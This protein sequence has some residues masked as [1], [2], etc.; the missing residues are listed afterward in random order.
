MSSAASSSAAM[1]P[2]SSSSPGGSTG[3]S[4]VTS[5]PCCQFT[6]TRR[7][8]YFGQS[9]GHRHGAWGARSRSHF[10]TV[11]PF[12][13]VRDSKYLQSCRIGMASVW[14]RPHPLPHARID[15]P[16][17]FRAIGSRGVRGSGRIAGMAAPIRIIRDVDGVAHV[18]AP[19]VLAAFEGQGFAAA[20]DRIWQMELDRRRALGTLAEVVGP[21]A[22]AV[23]SFH[24]RMGL[25]AHARASLEALDD[26]TRAVLDAYAAGVNRWLDSGADLPAEL[27]ALGVVPAPW[28][29]WH[30]IALYEVRH[31]AMGTY[32]TKLWRSGLVH[33]LGAD[34]VARLWPTTDEVLVDP[35]AADAPVR[36]EVAAAL[37][38][39]AALLSRFSL[40]AAGGTGEH[41]SNNLVI[42]PALTATGR[43]ILAGDPHRTIDLPNVYWQNH[44]T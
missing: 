41:G 37:P 15:R 42:G 29:G 38:A 32:E 31:L 33:R 3:V 8:V 26:E 5:V 25:A 4:G 9:S 2:S 20:E 39:G 14:H 13:Y 11:S 27:E 22:I 6:S 21:S 34:A 16:P 1:E 30:S 18:R 23:D 24:R 40:D 7:G 44:L 35:T 43:P 12:G 17:S 10:R 36:I 19:S 28:E